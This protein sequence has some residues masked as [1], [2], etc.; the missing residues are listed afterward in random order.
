M[1]SLK[2]LELGFCQIRSCPI[3]FCPHFQSPGFCHLCQLDFVPLAFVLDSPMSTFFAV[4]FICEVACHIVTLLVCCRPIELE[5]LVN[6]LDKSPNNLSQHVRRA[7]LSAAYPK[8][9]TAQIAPVNPALKPPTRNNSAF[10]KRF[11]LRVWYLSS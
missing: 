3:R 8:F 11:E 7:H 6:Q 9:I 2:T 10:Y 4:G 1:K 5:I